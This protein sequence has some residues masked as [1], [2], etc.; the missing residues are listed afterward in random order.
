MFA[1]I[2]PAVTIVTPAT[3]ELVRVWRGMR[4]MMHYVPCEPGRCTTYRDG[5]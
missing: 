5:P 2:E 1:I 4:P 3:A